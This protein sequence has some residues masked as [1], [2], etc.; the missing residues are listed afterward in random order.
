MTVEDPSGDA[1][2]AMESVTNVAGSQQAQLKGLTKRSVAAISRD[3]QD[4]E[5]KAGVVCDDGKA[6]TCDAPDQKC[7]PLSFDLPKD[8]CSFFFTSKM[9][10][11]AFLFA[12]L[13]FAFQAAILIVVQIGMTQ[14]ASDDN[15]FSVPPGVSRAVRVSQFFALTLA[16]VTQDD[17]IQS[18]DSLIVRYDSGVREIFPSASKTKWALSN[19]LRG[20]HGCLCLVI[21]F[22]LTMQ[23]SVTLSVFLNFA[24]LQFISEIDDIGWLL[25]S[26]GCCGGDIEQMTKRQRGLRTHGIAF[27]NRKLR[28]SAKLPRTLILLLVWAGL[29]TG[30]AI[31]ASQQK[32]GKFL[33]NSVTVLFGDEVWEREADLDYLFYSYF[34]GQYV[35]KPGAIENERPVY[36]ERGRDPDID[37]TRP[38]GKFSY[39]ASEEAWV[40]SIDTITKGSGVLE[41]GCNWLLKSPKSSSFDLSAVGSSG[42]T[43]WTGVVTPPPVSFFLVSCDECSSEADSNY[44]GTCSGETKHCICDPG[45]MGTTCILDDICEEIAAGAAGDSADR[46]V[47]LR[48]ETDEIVELYDR[49]VYYN[50]YYNVDD[51]S[52]NATAL[53]QWYDIETP[54]LPEEVVEYAKPEHFFH[55][56]WDAIYEYNTWFFSEPTT[57]S[58]TVGLEYNELIDF[59]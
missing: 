21:V 19:I 1:E 57:E 45:W 49:P 53:I 36:Y 33:C 51:G 56:Y 9:N 37:P 30:G 48:D 16:P 44:H 24:A 22:T 7:E 46:L 4:D 5:E 14:S 15:R 18:L 59:A 55:A 43:I 41:D 50:A 13:V 17:F 28:V 27:K 12:I 29:F 40:F 8:A 47:L 20:L 58:T 23:A 2:G 31:I 6:V 11:P 34:S 25:A 26:K 54:L 35:L 3:G 10:H 52:H 38:P 32:S 42:W 39:C